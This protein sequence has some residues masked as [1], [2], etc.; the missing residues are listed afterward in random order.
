MVL[1]LLVYYGVLSF[2]SHEPT[3]FLRI[4]NHTVAAQ[5]AASIMEWGG[6]CATDLTHALQA[7]GDPMNVIRVLDMYR[8]MLATDA[9]KN[10]PSYSY[11]HETKLKEHAGVLFSI[12]FNNILS[13]PK[14]EYTVRKIEDDTHG[15]GLRVSITVET[16]TDLILL[17]LKRIPVD[18]I[19]L[20]SRIY[21]NSLEREAFIQ[22]MPTEELLP[23]TI[24]HRKGRR[25]KPL[26]VEDFVKHTAVPQL[27]SSLNSANVQEMATKQNL[28]LSGYAVVIVGD[29]QILVM[30]LRRD[31]KD[32]KVGSISTTNS[33]TETL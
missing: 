10:K 3:K 13:R 8:L 6:L 27:R 31:G 33:H 14:H 18:S 7:P 26:V 1:K 22:Q 11:H 25:R 21:G 28:R 15:D 4:P 32:W 29:R 12:L 19:D 30:R 24:N 16:S 2:D 23:L 20:S 17:A 9:F 5:V